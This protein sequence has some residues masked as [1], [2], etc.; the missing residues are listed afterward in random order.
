[1]F[2]CGP[3]ILYSGFRHGTRIVDLFDRRVLAV[4]AKY[5]PFFEK[6]GM[7]EIL[8]SRGETSLNG[9]IRRFLE[10]LCFDFELAKSKAYCRDFLVA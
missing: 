3:L 6:A 2:L 7:T 1:M 5:N 10:E 4:M 9:K 8:Y